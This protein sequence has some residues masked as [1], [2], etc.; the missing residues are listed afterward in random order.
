MSAVSLTN[1]ATINRQIAPPTTQHSLARMF[2]SLPTEVLGLVTFSVREILRTQLDTTEWMSRRKLR[3]TKQQQS[4]LPGLAVPGCY[5][6]SFCFLV[7][8]KPKT[9]ILRP[10]YGHLA[11]GM[12]MAARTLPSLSIDPRVINDSDQVSGAKSISM[13]EN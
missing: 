1:G 4:M 3:E 10:T 2:L 11:Q 12:F 9:S 13:S 6:V 7:S 5:L 8:C